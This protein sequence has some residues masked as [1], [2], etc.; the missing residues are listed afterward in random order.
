MAK[1]VRPKSLPPPAAPA[2]GSA[3]ALASAPSAGAPSAAAAPKRYAKSQKLFAQALTLMPGGVSSPVRSFKSVGID[4][5]F[6]KEAKGARLTDVD[7]NTYIDYVMSYGPLIAGHCPPAVRAAVAKQ[8]DKGSSYG[9][10]SETE[11]QLAAQIAQAM[12]HVPMIRFVNSGTEAT[13]SALRLARGVTGRDV[14]VKC[15]GCY[16]GHADLLLV[17]AG[18]GATTHGH[19]S[20]PGV[21]ESTT[22]NTAIVPFNDLDAAAALFEKIGDKIAAIIIEPI[23]GN[24]GVVP[25]LPGYL[26][27]LRDLCD[28]YSALLIFD[29]VMTG[30]RVALGGAQAL[31]GVR[32]DITCLGKIIG[33]GLPVG[34][35]GAKPELM[36][37]I[38]PAGPI[39]Q[40][41]TLSGNPLSMAAGIA[42]LSLLEDP[43]VYASLEALGA[44]LE[45]G[46]IDAAAATGV[47]LAI[48]RVGAMITPFFLSGTQAAQAAASAAPTDPPT[49]VI[50]NYADALQCD[51]QAYAKFFRAMLD[52]GIMLPPSQFEAWFLS[53]AHTEGDID[54]TLDTARDALRTLRA[55]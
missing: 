20:S 12:P 5:V 47:P 43:D 21:P 2:P 39:Y 52:A 3:P 4:P 44:R 29:E 27:G 16:H 17:Q 54:Q 26:E 45:H 53:T 15:A 33:G 23:C 37:H 24:I 30:F 40:A 38:S 50:R 35:Y 18:S 7:G 28:K 11:V 41:G 42:T 1:S 31:L 36:N 19:P 25:P 46:L 9:C 8:I 48:Q 49:P 55:S 10:C 14:I 13:M 22:Q 6:I 32:P 34:A 51:T